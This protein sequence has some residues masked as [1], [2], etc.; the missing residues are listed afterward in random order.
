MSS[1]PNSDEWHFPVVSSDYIGNRD[2][3][4]AYALPGTGRS[5]WQYPNIR[6]LKAKLKLPCNSTVY[7]L[8]HPLFR[9]VG[10]GLDWLFFP[11]LEEL[12]AFLMKSDT[13]T[14]GEYVKAYFHPVYC[15]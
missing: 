11:S 7:M 6:L 8:E 9:T 12:G 1:S 4:N 10:I 13:I 15:S 2:T 3:W 5:H 14:P